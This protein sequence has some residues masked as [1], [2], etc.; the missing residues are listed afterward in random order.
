MRE[1]ENKKFKELEVEEIIDRKLAEMVGEHFKIKQQ[2]ELNRDLEPNNE[3]KPHHDLKSHHHLKHKEPIKLEFEFD[4]KIDTIIN[5]FGDESTAEA[6]IKSLKESPI[7]IQVLAQIIID[8]HER[9]D[10][11]L[12]E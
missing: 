5:V 1:K 7:E 11:A 8:L 4:E 6:I 2:E 12:G 10:E 9:L 3:P